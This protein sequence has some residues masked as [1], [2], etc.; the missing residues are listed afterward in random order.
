MHKASRAG[1][2]EDQEPAEPLERV[3]GLLL[4]VVDDELDRVAAALAQA[5]GVSVGL[6]SRTVPLSRAPLP[7]RLR[8]PGAGRIGRTA[9]HRRWCRPSSPTAGG[10]QAARRAPVAVVSVRSRNR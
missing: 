8:R 4:D 6:G 1:D 10:P 3:E 7:V 5:T 2:P 9:R